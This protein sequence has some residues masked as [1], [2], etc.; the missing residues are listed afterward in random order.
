VARRTHELGIRVALGAGPREILRAVML[1]GMTVILI[2]L[3]IGVVASLA[4]TRLLGGFLFGVK[5]FD[6]L[7]YLAVSAVLT[8]TALAACYVPARR[9]T[10]MTP[11]GALRHE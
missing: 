3:G 9:A 7:T 6:P 5:P 10:R 1:R 11:W 2:G 4:L 8:I